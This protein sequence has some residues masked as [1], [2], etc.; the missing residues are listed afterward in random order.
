LL[1]TLGVYEHFNISKQISALKFLEGEIA[2]GTITIAE[3]L[4]RYWQIVSQIEQAS[5]RIETWTGASPVSEVHGDVTFLRMG[6]VW[7][8]CIGNDNTTAFTYNSEQK[9][10]NIVKNKEQTAA[11]HKA[12]K[13]T[14]GMAAPQLIALPFRI[15]LTSLRG[16]K[17][18]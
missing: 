17:Y 12:I 5:F 1:D 10:F 8:A 15:D 4:E 3:G 9:K 2:A 16:D 7:L 18:Q 13:L 6:F 11:I 14:S